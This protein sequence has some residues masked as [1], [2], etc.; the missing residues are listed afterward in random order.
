VLLGGAMTASGAGLQLGLAAG[1]VV[2]GVLL[3]AYC[4][5]VADTDGGGP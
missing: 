1:L 2:G 4:L 3:V 5:L